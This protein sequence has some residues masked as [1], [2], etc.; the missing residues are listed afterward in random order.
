MILEQTFIGGT[1]ALLCVAGLW[2]QGW[3]LSETPK[4]QKLISRLGEHGAALTVRL[5]LVLGLIFGL[6]LAAGF[7]H[8]IRWSRVA[9]PAPPVR[10]TNG[11][12]LPPFAD[13]HA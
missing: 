4:G 7:V 12:A 3:L 9:E 2:H 5:L 1:T 6:A 8:P 11:R 10:F 13:S